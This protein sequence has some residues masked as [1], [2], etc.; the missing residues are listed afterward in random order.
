MIIEYAAAR[1]DLELD[2]LFLTVGHRFGRGEFRRRMRDHVRRLLA[3]GPR[4][5]S[6]KP[7]EQA[8]RPTPDGLPI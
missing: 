8:G 3:R 1:W 2:D 6:R 7:A 5:S 4:T